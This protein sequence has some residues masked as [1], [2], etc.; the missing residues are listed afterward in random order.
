MQ[1]NEK[2]AYQRGDHFQCTARISEDGTHWYETMIED[3]SSG[4]LLFKNHKEYR[5]GDTLWF[6]VLVEG[7]LAEFSVKVQGKVCRVQHTGSQYAHGI[8]F[9]GLNND[10]KIRIDENV[11]SIRRWGEHLKDQN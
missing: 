2:R 6:D 4:G 5:V 8:A 11:Q 10:I 7:F 1:I 9:L 3:L